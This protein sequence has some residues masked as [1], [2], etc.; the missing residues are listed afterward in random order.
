MDIIIFTFILQHLVDK[1]RDTSHMNT[2][3][4]LYGRVI[5]YYIYIYTYIYIMSYI[6][7]VVIACHIR[8]CFSQGMCVCV[9]VCVCVCSCC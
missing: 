6:N 3:C 2:L 9:C 1:E 4:R 7:I 5:S 8:A